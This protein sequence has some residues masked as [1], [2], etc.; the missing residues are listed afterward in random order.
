MT[1]LEVRKLRKHFGGLLAV[2]DLDFS[3][4]KGEI[5]GLIGPNGAGKTTIFDIISGFLKPDLGSVLFEGREIMGS[6][7]S[8]IC[9]SGIC[10]TFQLAKPFF[11]LTVTENVMIGPLAAGISVKKAREEACRVLES[12]GLSA[13]QS[14]EAHCLTGGSKKRLELAKALATK[15]KLLMVDEVMAGLN[16][17]EINDMILILRKVVGEGVTLLVVEHIMKAV[18]ALA[19]RILV[20]NNGEKIAQGSASE[21]VKNQKVLDAYL[22]KDFSLRFGGKERYDGEETS[23]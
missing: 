1:L 10:R 6:R 12:V 21:I 23:S 15:P 8:Q 7:P 3:I 11:H 18:M 20:V 19:D 4:Q 13:L 17:N 9:L 22:G 16:D 2:K 5:F 14:Q